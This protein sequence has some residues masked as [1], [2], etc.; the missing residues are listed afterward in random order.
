[1][2]CPGPFCISAGVGP[3]QKRTARRRL[4]PEI[5]RPCS[6]GRARAKPCP[7]DCI[8]PEL[9]EHMHPGIHIRLQE[10]TH[11]P[12]FSSSTREGSRRTVMH[13]KTRNGAKWS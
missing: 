11:P 7:R 5:G 9:R 3:S 10:V 1:M 4:V 12:G 13:A 2:A 8:W 6:L